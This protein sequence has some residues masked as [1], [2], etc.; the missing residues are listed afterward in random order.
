[1]PVKVKLE[2]YSGTLMV[3]LEKKGNTYVLTFEAPDG[4]ALDLELVT[5]LHQSL[6]NVIEFSDGACAL[7]LTGTG[8]SFCSG[9]SLAAITGYSKD[10]QAEF[11]ASLKR[12]YA[13]LVNFPVPTLAALN[14]HA[15][16]GGAFLALVCDYRVMREDRGWF[17]ISEV[18]VGVPI[19]PSIMEIARIKMAANVLRD[20]VLTGKRFGAPESVELGFVDA[21]CT[22]ANLLDMALEIVNPIAK[23]ERKIFT[24]L[25]T[26]LYGDCAEGLK[27]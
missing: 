10:Q 20:A 3:N 23:K 14:G 5:Q 9:L 21:L 18:D 4:N 16:A 26:S 6:D 24:T 13:R 7:V 1:M 12:L 22:E 2:K 27:A 15:I 11:F 19:E 17:C 25:K 8:K